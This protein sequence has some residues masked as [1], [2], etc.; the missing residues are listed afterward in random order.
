MRLRSMKQC[1]VHSQRNAEP[2]MHCLNLTVDQRLIGCSVNMPLG[3]ATRTQ[4]IP[5]ALRKLSR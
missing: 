2:M 1:F 4:R 5:E 3:K